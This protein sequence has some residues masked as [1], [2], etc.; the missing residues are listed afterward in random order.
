MNAGWKSFFRGILTVLA[1]IAGALVSFLLLRG[2]KP[3]TDS[4]QAIAQR[5]DEAIARTSEEIKSDSDQALADRFNT[6][7]KKEDSK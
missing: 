1:A 7:A 5:A 2:R 4:P 3:P 6:I